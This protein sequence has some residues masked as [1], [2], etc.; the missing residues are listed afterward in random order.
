LTPKNFP[1]IFLKEH[2]FFPP[3]T[4]PISLSFSTAQ[5]LYKPFFG[6]GGL[7]EVLEKGIFP[8]DF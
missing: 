3:Y 8:E 2:L 6:L 4:S 7:F 5:T 1:S